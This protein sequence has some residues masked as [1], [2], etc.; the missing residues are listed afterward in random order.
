[1]YVSFLNAKLQSVRAS[2][3]IDGDMTHPYRIREI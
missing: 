2:A 1:M 3:T